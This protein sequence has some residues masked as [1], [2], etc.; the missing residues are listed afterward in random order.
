MNQPT[1][2]GRRDA[3][4]QQADS[5][6]AAM[7]RFRWVVLFILVV[8]V[9][10]GFLANENKAVEYVA[11]ADLIVEDPRASSVEVTDLARQSTQSSE[12]YLADQVEILRSTEAA[13]IASDLTGGAFS[14]KQVLERRDIAGD[15]TSNLIEISFRAET[16]ADAKTGADALLDAYSEL[17]RRQVQATAQAA[18]AE[19]DALTQAIDDELDQIDAAIADLL[20]VDEDR[21]ALQAQVEEA[22][23]DLNALRETR[24]TL[25]VGSAARLAINEQIAEL[26]AD[27]ETWRVVLD[28]E[29]DNGAL[30]TLTAERDAAITERATLASQRNAIEVDA[31]LAAAGVVLAS[32]ASLPEDPAGIPDTLVWAAAL[33]L[34]LV[35]AAVFAYFL[36]LRDAGLTTRRTPDQVLGA[37][38]LAEVPDFGYEHITT[39]LPVKEEPASAA[40]ESFRFVAASIDLRLAT[41]N[42][43]M[44]SVVSAT[45]GA[46]KTTTVANTGLAAA[47]EGKRI[48]L[49]DGDFGNQELTR[50]LVDETPQW[51]ITDIVNGDVHLL[52][53]LVDVPLGDGRSVSLLSRGQHPIEAASFYQS[54]VTKDFFQHL[55]VLYDLVLVDC[56]P[57]LQ[58][59]YGSTLAAYTQASV[60]LVEHASSTNQLQALADRLE[61]VATPVLGYVYT[62]A[63]L[64]REMTAGVGSMVNVLGT[65][66]EPQPESG[67]RS[68]LRLDGG[69]RGR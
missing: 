8:F 37:P 18:L 23:R 25:P 60:V 67:W 4:D 66:E 39:P 62:K 47:R 3:A 16:P 13:V 56:P 15:A 58:V 28:I 64:R 30:T 6:L 2:D 40:A 12:R 43:H 51:G 61:V 11:T 59:A 35:A 57:L 9:A 50:L 42:A 21:V 55:P 33:G 32:P 69:V 34:G 49:V 26:L 36:S 5:L 38:L 20:A 53:A 45:V 24:A 31:E 44:V 48:L 52:Q 17:R 68:R 7:W 54:V 22:I 29:F 1:T 63:P 14:S 41:A 10:V 65:T 27:F 19:I 46:G